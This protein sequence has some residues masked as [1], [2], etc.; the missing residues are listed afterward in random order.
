MGFVQG[1]VQDVNSPAGGGS[2]P[3]GGD[4]TEVDMNNSVRQCLI[5]Y[6]MN[7]GIRVNG[8]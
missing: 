6:R 4:G 5:C 7:E 3:A 2:V 1:T 8:K